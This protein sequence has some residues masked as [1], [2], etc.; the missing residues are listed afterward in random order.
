MRREDGVQRR[1][2]P[3]CGDQQRQDGAVGAPERPGAREVRV[4]GEGRHAEVGEEGQVRAPCLDFHQRD[5]AGHGDR[6]R[7]KLQRQEA[8]REVEHLQGV[9]GEVDGAGRGHRR[10]RGEPTPQERRLGPRAWSPAGRA[11]GRRG[12]GRRRRAGLQAHLEGGV[13]EHGVETV[14]FNCHDAAD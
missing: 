4:R 9:R 8:G 6:G 1:V 7:R 5:G 11:A 14:A 12:G 13:A 3:Y 10:K 2:A